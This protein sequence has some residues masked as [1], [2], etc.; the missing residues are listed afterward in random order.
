MI[1]V[2]ILTLNEEDDLPRCLASLQW[3]DDIHVIDSGSQDKTL[4][5][6]KAAGTKVCQHPFESFGSQRN[7]TLANCLFRHEWVLFL[8]ADECSTMEFH[9]SIISAT[10]AAPESVAGFYLCWKTILDDVW[11]KRCDSFPKWQF[12]LMRRGRASFADFGHGQ[13]EGE[14]TGILEY[15][16]EPYLHFAFSKGW[17]RWIERHNRYSDQEAAQRLD[18]RIIWRDVF[19]TH[20]SVRNKALKP[21]V[22]RIP[23]WPLA[24]F[25]FRYVVKLGFLEGGPGFV[26]C[27]NMAYYEFLIRIKMHQMRRNGCSQETDRLEPRATNGLTEG[28]SQGPG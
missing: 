25:I 27:V 28:A 21:L 7:W 8:D 15:V 12:R 9:H 17:A 16:R 14:V 5:L 18:T 24:S 22:S 23:A 2:A 26:F 13:K 11:L 20:G 4:D 6:A 19:S 1:S 10:E 3:C